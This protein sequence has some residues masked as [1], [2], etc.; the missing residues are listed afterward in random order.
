MLPYGP[1][2]T[3]LIAKNNS[4][5]VMREILSTILSRKVR[6]RYV[7]S[8]STASVTLFVIGNKTDAKNNRD[9]KKNS[10]N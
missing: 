10:Y 2:L 1:A 9:Q 5:E 6:V 7:L 3:P 4:R 8:I